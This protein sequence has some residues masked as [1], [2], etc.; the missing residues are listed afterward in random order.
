MVGDLLHDRTR[1]ASS[2]DDEE[3][4]FCAMTILENS[5][6]HDLMSLWGIITELSEQLNQNRSL[7]VSLYAQ[8]GGL[9]NQAIH[10]QTGFVL[11]RF[12]MDKTKEAYDAELTRMNTVMSAENQALQHDNKQLNTL[13]KEY[14]QTLETLMSNF[15]N[16]AQDVQERELTLIREYESKLLAREEQNVTQ[17]L[18]ANVEAS[19]SLTRLSELLR[20]TLHS[21]SGEDIEPPNAGPLSNEEPWTESNGSEYALEREIELARL[22][23][24]NEELRR[25]AG[26]LPQHHHQ[27]RSDSSD[28]RH[29]DAPP[30]AMPRS[31]S[32]HRIGASTGPFGTL[33]ERRRPP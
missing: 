1:L 17:E 19:G 3:Q 29:Y 28:Q 2:P 14:E 20:Q 4:L 30:S 8:A 23:K 16:R 6:D 21:L 22:E 18:S 12:N 7:A 15:R 26:L 32:Q 10:T 5:S 31:Q 24:E 9:K 33:L 27:R 11:R 13:I 25:L